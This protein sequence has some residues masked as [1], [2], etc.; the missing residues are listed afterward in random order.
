MAVPGF[1]DLSIG[2]PLL[3][4]VGVYVAVLGVAL[5]IIFPLAEE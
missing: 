2:T 3:F 4:D 1:G 5:S